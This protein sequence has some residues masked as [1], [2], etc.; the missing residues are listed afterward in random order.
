MQTKVNVLIDTFLA[1]GADDDIQRSLEIGKGGSSPLPQSERGRCV[2]FIEHDPRRM[3]M[4]ADR[5]ALFC[6][7]Q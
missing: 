5:R 6:K 1:K 3:C 4:I 7:G 2:L